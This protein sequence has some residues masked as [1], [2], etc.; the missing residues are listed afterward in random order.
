MG[1]T[2]SNETPLPREFDC[3]R[4]DAHVAVTERGDR[5]TVFCSPYCEREFWRHRSRYE[6]GK[7]ISRGHVT[8]EARDAWMLERGTR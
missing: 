7:R 4:C 2:Y 1:A 8:D 5:R 6:R 3:R